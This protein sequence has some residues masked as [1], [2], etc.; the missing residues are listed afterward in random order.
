VSKGANGRGTETVDDGGSDGKMTDTARVS[1]GLPVYNGEAFVHRALGAL[2]AQDYGN[3]ELIISDNASTDG[4]WDICHEYAAM[5]SR[6]RLYRNDTNLGFIANFGIVLDHARAPYF[7][8]AGVDDYWAPG[9]IGALVNE[10]DSHPEAGLALSAIQGVREDGTP[11]F[12][13]RFQG[14]EDPNRMSY[15]RLYKEMNIWTFYHFYI[16]GLFRTS[17]LKAAFPLFP[18]EKI[19]AP[20]I[21]FMCQFALATRWR[22]VDRLLYTRTMWSVMSYER[23]PDTRPDKILFTDKGVYR[24]MLLKLAEIIWKSPI[25]PW[26]RKLLFPVALPRYMIHALKQIVRDYVPR[27]YGNR[28]YET[29]KRLC[30]PTI[31]DYLRPIKNRLT[32]S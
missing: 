30:P 31:R 16:Y 7:M 6:I 24:P 11:L 22:Y 21:M 32:R 3:F 14:R 25:I 17:L 27:E 28:L 18:S 4:T 9:L 15:Y 8:W 20:D 29:A 10:L 23:Y 26:Y 19:W 12:T 1:I 5:D 13:C 2:L